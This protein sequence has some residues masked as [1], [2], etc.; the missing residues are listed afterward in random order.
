[1]K[2]APQR[3]L[4][5]W[6]PPTASTPWQR[7]G[8]VPL[9]LQRLRCPAPD[10]P[11]CQPQAPLHPAVPS[12][13]SASPAGPHRGPLRP[14]SSQ[15][16]ELGF[17]RRWWWAGKRVL[18]VALG[19]ALPPARG[20]APCLCPAGFGSVP[21]LDLAHESGPGESGLWTG[22]DSG[23][24]GTCR[25]H[26]YAA[27]QLRGCLP[28]L[29]GLERSYAQL[30]RVRNVSGMT[31]AGLGVPCAAQRTTAAGCAVGRERR[32]QSQRTLL[33]ALQPSSCCTAWCCK[34]LHGSCS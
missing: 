29:Q 33:A 22:T 28:G 13:P 9:Q 34:P 23:G 16:P 2:Q 1:M 7:R 32:A 18:P 25:R 21:C 8:L 20:R 11:R 17:L 26:R 19:V 15:P 14:R 6:G 5:D 30:L 3:V 27:A 24:R 12:T 4:A 31:V 10:P